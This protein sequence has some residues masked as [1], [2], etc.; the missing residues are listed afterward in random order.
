[1]DGNGRWARKH[2]LP[3]IEGHIQGAKTAV[4]IAVYCNRIGIKTLALYS[5]SIE[6]WKRPRAEVNALMHLYEH[7]LVQ[8]RPILMRDNVRL[9]HLGR[10]SGL[11][12]GV[13]KELHQTMEE[14]RNNTGMTL[15]LAL[16]YGGRTEI[17]DAARGIAQAVK[18]GQLNVDDIDE[19][20]IN[21]H[22]Y[23][24][25]IEDPDL[26]IRTANE[27]RVSNFLLWQISYSEFVVTDCFWPDFSEEILEETF[28]A[29]A[30]RERRF[31]ALSTQEKTEQG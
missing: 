24:A 19:Q 7:Y 22:L 5:F 9:I 31:G 26:L 13:I 1:M 4:H 11:P 8:V 3:R 29:Y 12:E 30:A 14:T 18:D 25:P 17:I 10:Q 16:N 23:T 28:R 15:G 2:N 6:N 27:L 20:C 21:E